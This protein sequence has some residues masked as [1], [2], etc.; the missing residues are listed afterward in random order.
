MEKLTKIKIAL[1][2]PLKKRAEQVAKLLS[3]STSSVIRLGLTEF[4]SK[5]EST[6]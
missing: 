3:V 5:H 1:P 4:C 6:K 2:L